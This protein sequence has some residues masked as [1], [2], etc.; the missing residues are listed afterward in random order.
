MLDLSSVTLSSGPVALNLIRSE[1]GLSG[2]ISI[3]ISNARIEPCKNIIIH[4]TRTDKSL[5]LLLEVQ[6]KSDCA[7]PANGS[8][9]EPFPMATAIGIALSITFGL[10]LIILVT[11]VAVPTL[12][13]KCFP[14]LIKPSSRLTALRASVQSNSMAEN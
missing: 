11:I 12:R 2:N 9:A 8:A 13:Y 4:E 5:S 3:S 6:D 10:I 7:A 1:C 14:Y